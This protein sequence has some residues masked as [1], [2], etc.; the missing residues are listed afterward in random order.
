LGKLGAPLPLHPREIEKER[1]GGRSASDPKMF[2]VYYCGRKKKKTLKK[3]QT[4]F[5]QH[6]KR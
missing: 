5:K 3:F 4:I 1:E 2:S 6:I